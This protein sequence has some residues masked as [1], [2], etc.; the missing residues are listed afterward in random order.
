MPRVQWPAYRAGGG[1][2]AEVFPL[3]ERHPVPAQSLIR[4]KP[5]PALLSWGLRLVVG[6][7]TQS[8]RR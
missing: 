5:Q 6:A 8:N 2:R 1:V 7:Q 4:K 3:E